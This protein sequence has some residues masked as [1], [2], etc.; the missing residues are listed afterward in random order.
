MLVA[1]GEIRM[2][3]IKR[4]YEAPAQADGARFLVDRLWPRAIKKENLAIKAWLKDVAPSNELRTWY[5]R[6]PGQWEKFRLRYFA[7]LN[8]HP[9]AWKPLL[10]AA[11][12]GPLTLIYSAKRE[13]H[14][15]AEALKEF[16]EA[17][18]RRNKKTE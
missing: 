11:G 18:L 7:E 4:A 12:N 17:R 5:H 8:E 9:D 13:D 3:A 1:A 16:L 6:N 15:N 10:E 14:N 2:I